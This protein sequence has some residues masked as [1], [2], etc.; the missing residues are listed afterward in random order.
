MPSFSLTMTTFS[1]LGAMR[2]ASSFHAAAFGGCPMRHMRGAKL[3]RFGMPAGVVVSWNPIPQPKR[4]RMGSR[5]L[6]SFTVLRRGSLGLQ[7]G[8]E[9]PSPCVLV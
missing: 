1:P 6:E 4:A 3:T 7:A 8:E 9:A 2:P 5:N